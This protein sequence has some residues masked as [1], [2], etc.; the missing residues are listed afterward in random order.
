MRILYMDVDS[1]RPDHLGCYGYR[2]ATSPNMDRV[3]AEGVRFT[4]CYTSDAPCLPSRSALFSGR[5]G[6]HTGVVNHGGVA[7][8]PL[9]EGPGREFRDWFGR[10]AWPVRLRQA[11]YHTVAISPFGERHSAWHW[12]AGFNEVHNTGG[13]GGENADVIFDQADDWLQ[14]RGEQDT[15]F[16][17]LNFWDPHTAYRVPESFGNPFADEAH[18]DWL[19]EEIRRKH[20]AGSGPHSAR[21]VMGYSDEKPAYLKGDYPR[22]PWKIDSSEAVKQMFDGYDTG[23]RYVDEHIGRILNRLD[24]LG[25]LDETAIIISA[26]HGENLGELNVYGDHQT[27]DYCTCRVPLIIRWPGVTDHQQGRVDNGLHYHVDFAATSTELAGGEVTERWDGKSFASA[28]REGL[29]VSRDSLVLSQAAWCVQRAVRWKDHV[30][31]RSYHDAWHDYPER[32][33]FQIVDD[34]H[35]VNN[36]AP[37][38]APL[39]QEAEGILDAWQEAMVAD[40]PDKYD[41]LQTVLAEGG[42]LHA[43]EGGGAYLERLRQTGRASL[44][45][46]LASKH[47]F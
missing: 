10:N 13:G 32:M 25:V 41:P 42:S 36:L 23:V 35:E 6:I 40:N 29:E 16:M 43:R 34:P 1:L 4:N 30:Y 17:H 44:A 28:M 26:D 24:E 15:W 12:H 8:Q 45:D 38:A 18:P 19:T 11:G 37:S 9:I 14:R 47:G 20:W 3:A 27:A 33:L 39:C 22:Q 21:E 5:F 46:R 7:S 31:I 2:R